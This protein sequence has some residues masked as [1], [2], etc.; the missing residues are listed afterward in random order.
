MKWITST[1][2]SAHDINPLSLSLTPRE[3]P[4]RPAWMEDCFWRHA[5]LRAL[6]QAGRPHRVV[7]T[8]NLMD[9]LYAPVLTGEAV[10]ASLGG[11]LP[12]GLRAIRDG[13]GLPQLPDTGIIIIKG[14]GAVQPQTDA[15]ANAILETFKID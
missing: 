7:A 10:T 1:T 15:V 5:V 2:R 8:S 6:Q 4:W 9:G 11:P 13:E 14:R 12:A 3:C